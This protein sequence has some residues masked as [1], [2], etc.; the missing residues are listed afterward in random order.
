MARGR[1]KRR[2]FKQV[3]QVQRGRVIGLREGGA[4]FRE[5]AQRVKCN[6][7]TAQ[8]TWKKW[9]NTKSLKNLPKP[10]RPRITTARQDR[11]IH[12]KNY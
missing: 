12:K 1:P 2:K 10:G 9:E 5:I 4:S 6:E 8:R 3:D 7:G 11:M